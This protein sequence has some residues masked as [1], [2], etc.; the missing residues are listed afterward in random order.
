[1]AKVKNVTWKERWNRNTLQIEGLQFQVSIL[2]QNMSS[3]SSFP[4]IT[5]EEYKGKHK[6]Y[7]S[8]CTTIQKITTQNYTWHI[9][10]WQS[11]SR[12]FF[13]SFHGPWLINLIHKK[14]LYDYSASYWK[15]CFDLFPK[16]R[17]NILLF[18]NTDC[19]LS[20]DHYLKFNFKF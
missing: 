12:D 1:M 14:H 15:D 2:Y 11:H 20:N 7:N 19:Q 5:N 10:N 18:M 9:K 4:V 6:Q 17:R 8:V 16:F 13:L 3:L